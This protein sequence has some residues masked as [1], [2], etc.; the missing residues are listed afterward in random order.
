MAALA[1][2]RP[3]SRRFAP[4][5][6]GD[7]VHPA[8]W[9]A[10]AALIVVTLL[11]MPLGQPAA[12][13]A[14][15]IVFLGGGLPHGAYDIA[16]L[17]RSVALDRSALALAVGGYVAVALLM[18]SLWMT[19]PLVALVLF[20][21]VASVH[22]GEDWPMLEEPLLRFAAGAAVIAA[23]TIGHP[24]EVSSLFVAM[25]DPRAAIIAQIVT[26]AAPV[27][28]LVT[29]VGMAVAWRD[30]GHWAAAMA[31]CL[32]LL[33]VLPPVAGFALF[34]VFLHSP[35][36]LAHTRALLRDMSLVRWLGTGALLSGFAILGGWGLRSMAPSRFDPTVVAQAF[37]LLASVAVPHLLLS[38]WLE[39]RL[40][41]I[42][43]SQEKT[44]IS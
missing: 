8:Y 28:L 11:G 43:L 2:P 9:I 36:H 26:A 39:G 20:L 22:F 13:A 6:R 17:R 18:V 37:Q 23:A 1:D 33:V 38:R 19:V 12:V 42:P 7:F 29:I 25:S 32:V 5:R 16:L 10:A 14:A 3:S 35:R 15:T 41:S 24:A 44:A 40:I 31:S 21:A 4:L 34:F 27:A 30:G